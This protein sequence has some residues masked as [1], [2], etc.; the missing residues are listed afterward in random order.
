MEYSW[1]RFTYSIFLFLTPF[2]FPWWLV[3]IFACLG[4]FLFSKFF[5]IIALGVVMDIVFG[6]SGNS[7]YT[8]ILHT[9]LMLVVYGISV[10][11][12]TYIRSTDWLK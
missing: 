9:I 7:W 6:F 2:F 5:E 11:F 3:V 12:H 4:T 10:V 8:H 1:K